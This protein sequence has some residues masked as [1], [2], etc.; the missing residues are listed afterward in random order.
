MSSVNKVHDWCL[1]KIWYILPD[2]WGCSRSASPHQ[3]CLRSCKQNK[4]KQ[5]ELNFY[6]NLL[7]H[8]DSCVCFYDYNSPH[9]LLLHDQHVQSLCTVNSESMRTIGAAVTERPQG[10]AVFEAAV[11]SEAASLSH[12]QQL[13]LSDQRSL[14]NGAA[15]VVQEYRRRSVDLCVCGIGYVYVRG[16][17]CKPTAHSD[18][19]TAH[20]KA[21]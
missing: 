14:V 20:P 10:G 3:S 19:Q 11:R 1:W 17:V 12:Q 4:S 7:T 6:T 9:V 5:S 2:P 18:L 13:A 8:K 15:V 21:C 16:W